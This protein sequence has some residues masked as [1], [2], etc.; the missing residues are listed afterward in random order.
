[1]DT[2]T[3]N[4]VTIDTDRRDSTI[5]PSNAYRWMACP[6]SAALSKK[7]QGSDGRG[8]NDRSS[9]NAIDG[10][11]AHALI[12]Q[13]LTG[14]DQVQ[15]VDY[16]GHVFRYSGTDMPITPEIATSAQAAIDYARDTLNAA[17]QASSVTTYCRDKKALFRDGAV[18]VQMH[19]ELYL[20]LEW[21]GVKSLRGGTPDIVLVFRNE[22]CRVCGIE[23]IDFKHGA[24][25]LVNV[26]DN[27][28]LL[29]YAVAA[30]KHFDADGDVT[31]RLTIVQPRA[32]HR[33]G[34]IRSDT[35][36][37]NAVNRWR[38]SVLIP[39]AQATEML[40]ADLCPSREACSFCP[41]I[42][43]CPQ[44]RERYDHM[45]V[46]AN[47][48]VGPCETE[49]S[50]LTAQQAC[51]VLDNAAVLSLFVRAV[52]A[53]VEH[54]MHAG[55]TEYDLYYKIVHKRSSRKFTPE[56][57]A[58]GSPLLEYLDREFL[59]EKKPKSMTSIEKA[60]VIAAGAKKAKGVMA[61][62]TTKPEGSHTVV[63]LSDK[64]PRVRPTIQQIFSS[65]APTVE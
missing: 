34:P 20:P 7:A 42:E 9:K 10:I 29:C 63:P 21:L 17:S 23:V 61:R 19:S 32:H 31:V 27:P 4:I 28:Q 54:E 15:A 14:G 44:I 38:D 2:T 25:V 5:S 11:V 45:A 55:S 8:S 39:Q 30:L 22:D 16:H 37:A 60:L 3:M 26:E 13:C 49:V 41:A 62:V 64:R 40:N 1:M 52:T 36:S 58:D 56:A 48:F 35:T 33:D 53:R 57:F 12:N 65:C 43:T 47:E 24:G 18:T 46:I 6:G 59:S 51:F 50:R